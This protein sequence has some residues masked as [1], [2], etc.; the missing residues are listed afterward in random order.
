MATQEFSFVCTICGKSV[1]ISTCKTDEFGKPVHNVCYAARL[2]GEN[3]LPLGSSPE[4]SL[5]P[6]VA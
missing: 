6:K 2:A 1:D 5:S 4:Q 3:G